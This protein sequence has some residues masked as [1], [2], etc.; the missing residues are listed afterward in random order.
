MLVKNGLGEQDPAQKIRPGLI[1]DTSEKNKPCFIR[2][3]V[4]T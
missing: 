1:L 2:A 3:R 4:V